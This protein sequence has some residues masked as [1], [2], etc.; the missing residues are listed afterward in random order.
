MAVE[1]PTAAPGRAGGPLLMSMAEIAELARVKRPVVTTWRRRYPGFPAQAGGDAASP[2]FDS[3]QVADWLLATG[4]DM[5]GRVEADLGLYTLAGLGTGMPPRDLTA[6]LTALICLRAL[7]D[8]PL[9]D[10]SGDPGRDLL[11]GAARLDP[12]DGFMLSEL[13][14][15]PAGPEWL[16]AAVDELVEAAWGCQEAFERIMSAGNRFKAGD[17][18]VR[19]VTPEL[20]RLVAD[21][22]GASERARERTICVCDPS[23]GPGDL[24]VAVADA[25]G[26]DYELAFQAAE[27]D[28]FLARLAA[29]RLFV[30]GVGPDVLQLTIGAGLP[31]EWS[32]PDVIVTQIPYVPGESRS[33][34]EVMDRL[35]DISL[36]LAP[37]S[38]AVVLGPADVLAGDL[39][40]YS[41]AERTRAGL[42]SSGMAEAV[43]RLPGGLTPFRP[44]YELALWVLTS[45]YDS[46][47]RG[48]V[49]LADVSDRELTSEVT[50]ALV[51][52]VVTWR[53]DGYRP[54]AHTRAFGVQVKVSDL[55][56]ELHPLTARRPAGV[57]RRAT[58]G[59]DL[60][61]HVTDIE[62]R[63][64]RLA[65]NATSARQ[66]V[67][68]Q[69]AAGV[70][71][72]L[73][74]Q[75]IGALAKT[76]RLVI[77]PG[78]RL[79]GVPMS[80]DGHHDVL[81]VPELMGRTRRGNRRIDRVAL[82]GHPRAQ[83][84]EP[85]DVIVTTTPDF[86]A[87]IDHDGLAIAEFPAKVLRIPQA[88][89][90]SFT[91]RTLAGLL[92]GRVPSLRTAGAVRPARRLEDLQIP[93]LTP[94]EVGF[95]DEFLTALDARGDAAQQELDLL[96]ELR[97]I[98][99]S[100]LL[101]GR[102]TITAPPTVH[103]GQ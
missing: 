58:T 6:L 103:T 82:A 85:G 96:T 70:P 38:T 63:L 3:R 14:L 74:R 54:H 50:A 91:P 101:D 81:G 28:A 17:L 59:P 7:D 9:A 93:L 43:I 94:A 27:A 21:L 56:N 68:S 45:A 89:R 75:T 83:L 23:A 37:G 84:T 42:L 5:E 69:V 49:L 39:R 80:E 10:S 79:R 25:A 97:D 77:K 98:T 31:E 22:S 18:Y 102:L 8:E 76:R 78:T 13:A 11:R 47:W 87:L 1:S 99:L 26:P 73:P 66:P 100:G 72:S 4:R 24:L 90:D 61:S 95:L 30:H 29:R 15:L 65:A 34:A 19:T 35:D 32:A 51:E 20:A 64:D 60:I 36:R 62:A 40:P 55:V 88:E 41:Q 92:A 52:D 48:W 86:R 71:A 2:L 16:A 12:H 44:G 53:R 57:T 46:P 33:P 67:R